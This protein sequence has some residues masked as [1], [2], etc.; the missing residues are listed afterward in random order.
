MPPRAR[1]RGLVLRELKDELIVYD[2]ETHRA[3]CLDRTASLVFRSAD[4]RR[5][6]ADLA[7]LLA[8]KTSGPAD[9]SLVRCALGSLDEAGLL[10]DR[11][12]SPE[13]WRASDSALARRDVLRRVGIGAAA[14]V[15]VVISLLVP[16]PAEAA[17]TCLRQ[18]DCV[19]GVNDGE[20]CYVSNPATDCTLLTCQG[21]N[22]C[23]P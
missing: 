14:L 1:A 21:T 20:P 9:P 8:E 5:S 22:V 7:E 13:E 11:G 12:S 6:V 23:L 2:K 18:Q 19:S 3:H 10:E 4:G 16:T 15:P 17:A